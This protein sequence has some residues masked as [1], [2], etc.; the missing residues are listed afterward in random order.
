MSM[1]E[2]ARDAAILVNPNEID[3]ISD[4]IEQITNDA[5]LRHSLIYKG[6]D[7]AKVFSWN[8][9]AESTLLMYE[10]VYKSFYNVETL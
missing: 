3:E 7:R 9:T 10:S 4:A 1:A 2:V 6:F 5:K 8:I